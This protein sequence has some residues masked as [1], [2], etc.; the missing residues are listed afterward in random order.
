LKYQSPMRLLPSII[1]VLTL[2]S[3]WFPA[4]ASHAQSKPQQPTVGSPPESG[5]AG[6]SAAIPEPGETFRDC[7]DCTEMVVV[8][9]GE[10]KMG[11]GDSPSEKP[12]H[13]VVIA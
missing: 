5:S 4:P 7:P 6:A 8:P 3:L 9:E 2:V 13:R 10:F 1:M 11:S 12:E